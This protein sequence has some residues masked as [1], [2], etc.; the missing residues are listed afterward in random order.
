MHRADSQTGST[1][2]TIGMLTNALPDQS[3]QQWLGV[4]DAARANGCNFLAFAGG[5]LD[6]P[7]RYVAQQN[8]VYDLASDRRLD[9]LIVW[10]SALELYIG[11]ERMEQFCSRFVPMPIVSME[12]PLGDAPVVRMGDR[13][14]M[15]DAVSH[16]V[17]AHHKRRIAF[18]RGPARHHGAEERYQGYVDA[19]AAH[20]LPPEP[21]LVT[22]PPASWAAAEATA[23]TL[24]L[25]EGEPRPDAIV[26]ANDEVAL[27]ALSALE[28]LRIDSPGE[29]AVIG[30]DDFVNILADDLGFETDRP[31][32]A[33]QAGEVRPST[34]SLTTARAP[35]YDM[36]WQAVELV[37]TALAGDA[38]PPVV[39]VPT[40][41]VVRRSCGCFGAPS[42]R[43]TATRHVAAGPQGV[44][45]VRIRAEASARLRDG[46]GGVAESLPRDWADALVSAYMSD[47][48]GDGADFLPVLHDLVGTT[49]RTFKSAVL[50]WH[51]LSALRQ[52]AWLAGLA[53][54]ALAR[55]AELWGQIDSLLSDTVERLADYRQVLAGKRERVMREIGQRLAVAADVAELGSVLAADLP[56]L[57]IPSCYVARYAAVVDAPPRAHAELLVACEQGVARDL[58]SSPEPFPS[59]NLVPGGEL[60]R[61]EPAGF[62]VMPLHLRSVQLGYALFE[63]GPRAGSVYEALQLPLSIG[64]RGVVQAGPA[65]SATYESARARRG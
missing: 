34:L 20:N 35:F 16:L 46:L 10:T 65:V 9:A 32:A 23:A 24:R 27:G 13:R 33:P 22:P 61:P 8:A 56:R 60:H 17:G 52:M 40:E 38:V 62:V 36:G 42:R 15:F 5:E 3:D 63:C 41:L 58:S 50:W 12:Q 21:M 26:G 25:L 53:D 43:G 39:T 49:V 55:A 47:L 29:V 51:A 1:R 30:F 44:G 4:A 37:I 11:H 6:D 45:E 59:Q 2:P 18:V 14:G 19:L 64:L 7:R 54:G 31:G 57:G 28:T 48:R